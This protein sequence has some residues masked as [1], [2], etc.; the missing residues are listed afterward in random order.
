[1]D[2]PKR[3]HSLTPRAPA[4]RP[5]QWPDRLLDL[6]DALSDLSL[7]PLYIVGGA[8]RD[9]L[10]GHTI[11]DFDLAAPAG[12]AIKA[13]RRIA[14]HF[15]GDIFVMDREREVARVF[16]SF[17][18]GRLNLDIA[19][20][21]G[22]SLADDLEGRDFTVNAMAVDLHGDLSQLIDPLNGEKDLDTHVLRRCSLSSLSSDPVRSLRAVR[23][24][25]GF[26]LRIE[27]ETLKDVKAAAAQLTTISPERVRDEWVKLLSLEKPA[28]ALR[29]ARAVGLLHAIV[30]EVIP[31]QD[32][33]VGGPDSLSVW[34]HV[35]LAIEKL[36]NMLH[37]ISYQRTDASAAAFDLGMMVIQFDRYRKQLNDHLSYAW[38]NERPHRSLLFFAVLLHAIGHE[39]SAVAALAEQRA[40][41]L[42]YSS[43]EIKRLVTIVQVAPNL[44]ETAD[45]SPLAQHRFWH[46]YGE[47]GLDII[48]VALA[49]YLGTV[50]PEIVQVEWLLRVDRARTLLSAYYDLHAQ[51]VAPP[52]L[53]NGDDLIAALHQPRGAWVGRAL[54]RIREAQVVGD[55]TTFDDAIALARRVLAE[56]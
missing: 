55:V 53:V 41:T 35:L 42:K 47:V 44:F 38:P 4:K 17:P 28:S 46:R 25:V 49:D 11:Y 13:A 9:A 56:G 32:V 3:S 8:V 43:G 19:G 39:G 34:E 54:E 21:R 30:P 45:W 31:L 37:V 51:I 24:S 12:D 48:L 20:F 36:G 29:V 10:L 2:D 14:D 7:P 50:G 33:K 27:P 22:E 15:K 52:P 18:E 26:G 1:M 23:Q 6:Q 5:L 40:M 16:L